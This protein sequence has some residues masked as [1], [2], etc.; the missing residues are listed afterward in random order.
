MAQLMWML[1][2][3]AKLDYFADLGSLEEKPL[4]NEDL[5]AI[6]DRYFKYVKEEGLAQ[7]GDFGTP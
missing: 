2:K 3:A 5:T 4:T 6:L 7:R 1:G